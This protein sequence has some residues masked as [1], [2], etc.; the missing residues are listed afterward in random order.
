LRLVRLHGGIEYFL[1]CLEG[2]AFDDDYA[3]RGEAVTE[4]LM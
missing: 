2:F 1:E 4:S 3:F